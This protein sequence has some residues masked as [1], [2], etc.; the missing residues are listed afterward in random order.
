[1]DSISTIRIEGTTIKLIQHPDSAYSSFLWPCALVL[2]RYLSQFP[3]TET[4]QIIELGAGIALPS[5]LLSKRIN[6]RVLATDVAGTDNLFREIVEN[7]LNGSCISAELSYGDLQ[8]TQALLDT[9]FPCNEGSQHPLDLILAS[10]LFYD[11]HL[12]WESI[13]ETIKCMDRP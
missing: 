12:D 1:M 5:L 9:C 2:S 11:N 13:L 4:S 6:A 3:P 10:D 8:T 7:G